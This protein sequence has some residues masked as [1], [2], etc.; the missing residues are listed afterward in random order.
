[1]RERLILRQRPAAGAVLGTYK[2]STGAT[3]N[4]AIAD[5]MLARRCA[6]CAAQ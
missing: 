4:D 2:Y 1:M 3:L 5:N 6:E